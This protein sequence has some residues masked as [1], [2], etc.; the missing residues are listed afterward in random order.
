M[1]KALERVQ[2]EDDAVLLS[3]ATG[4]LIFVPMILIGNAIGAL[5]RFPELGS[6]VVF[7]PYAVLTAALVAS[8]R[9]HWI[10]YIVVA[11]LAHAVA[12]LPTWS[13]SW[14]VFAD[15]ANIA[16]ALVAAVGLRWLFGGIPRLDGGI[17]LFKFFAIAVILAPAVGATLGSA[18]VVLHGRSA[19]YGEPWAQW[20]LSSAL[21]AVTLLPGLLV[22]ATNYCAWRGTRPTARRVI[23]ALS[24]AAA[25][26]VTCISVFVLALVPNGTLTWLLYAPLPLLIWAALRF[27]KG[28]A[29]F[30]LTTVVAI[31]VWGVDLGT[32]PFTSGSPDDN[33]LSLQL[34]ILLTAFPVLCIAA[35][36]AAR[37]NAVHLYRALLASLQD[38]VAVLDAR[39]I[40]LEVNHS[41]EQFADTHR[42]DAL[43]RVGA[44]DDYLEACSTSIEQHRSLG[45]ADDDITAFRI[46]AGVECVLAGKCRRFEME[47]EE[48]DATSQW[49]TVRVENLERPD[50]GV[51]VTRSNVSARH[52]AQ[53][54]IIQQR[55]ELSH[56]A[57]V[58][59]LGQ[60]SGA[61]AHELR[62]PL[63]AILSNA[64]TGQRM[65]RHKSVDI[66]QIIE[67]FQEIATED[68]RAAQVID[69]L[70]SLLKR[71]ETIVQSVDTSSL[72]S[73]VLTLAH[74][75][76]IA[77]RVSLTTTVEP[78]LPP[79][80]ADRVQVQ[81][82]LL[83]LILNACDAM[84]DI[85]VG[86]RML[87]VT[88]TAVGDNDVHFAVRD[89]GTGIPSALLGR[90]FDSFVTTKTNGLGLG[91]SISRSIVL[92][93]GGQIWAEN[94]A[95]GGATFHCVL[96][97][98]PFGDLTPA[99]ITL[100]QRSLV[101]EPMLPRAPVSDISP[102]A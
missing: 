6:A 51:V 67:I 22:A 58:A 98:A 74:A 63:S 100:R 31:A 10:W 78:G 5:L 64:E 39:G 25:L 97:S 94:N 52:R 47:Y 65:L 91:L 84:S 26:S 9:R 62:Q 50:G 11:V 19:T 57:R 80:L 20:F 13:L 72:I 83:N 42:A 88:A 28:G 54:E 2:V 7:P 33:V 49:Y 86:E 59:V 3:L 21:T 82:V 1:S 79:L 17:A 15:V 66:E 32:G 85:A 53:D 43:E 18:N 40:V 56:L 87:Y 16:R 96:R 4:M 99:Q 61:F 92:A 23:E 35:I 30:A 48:S 27:G 73:E 71:G 102:R 41:W 75:E 44:G 93:H 8:P 77:Q 89:A 24:L 60:L 76:V 34:F 70:R 68:R 14:V 55:S 69:G 29:S 36:G 46:L 38:H 101:E 95:N 90:L 81:Q 45:T 12:S 37:R